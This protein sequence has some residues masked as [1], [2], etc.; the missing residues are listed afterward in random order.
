MI[1]FSE[2]LSKGVYMTML[3]RFL[4]SLRFY[5][6]CVG[7]KN[8]LFVELP[9]FVQMAKESRIKEYPFLSDLVDCMEDC[10]DAYLG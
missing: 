8:T 4:K 6:R 5:I 2:E 10:E 9:T 7:L 1:P 3:K